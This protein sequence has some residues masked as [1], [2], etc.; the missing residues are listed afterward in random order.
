M[1]NRISCRGCLPFIAGILSWSG[2]F[3]Q[4]SV[5]RDLLTQIE[6]IRAVDN[7]AHVTPA[8]VPE[9]AEA[10]RPDPLGREPFAYPMRLLV[11]NAEY[12]DAWRGLY[13]YKYLDMAPDHT[14]EVLKTKLSLMREKGD[15][16]PSWVLDKANIAAVLVNMPSLGP[17]QNS[18]RFHWVPRADGFLF[19]FGGDDE[20]I[21]GFR[22][23]AG[24]SSQPATLA[25]YLETIRSRLDEWQAGGA[26]AIKFA[27]AYVRPLDFAPVAETDALRLFERH[28]QGVSLSAPEY[29]SVQ[30]FLFH[31]LAREAGRRGLI[32]QIHTGFGA[33]PYFNIGGSN[34]MLLEP[35][36]NDP[37]LRGTNFVLLHGGWP[38]DREAGALLMKPNVYADFSSQVFLRSTDALSSTL[39]TW[40]EW[41]PGKVL[42]GSDAYSE[43]TPLANWEEKI[44]LASRTSREALALALTQMMN[45]GEI[46]RARAVELAQM[47]LH[48]NATRLYGLQHP[49]ATAE[50]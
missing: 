13:E 9:T 47:V 18:S 12:V 2:V 50:R 43:D 1:L 8:R 10:E 40:L 45:A 41:Y 20:H 14:R 46:T 21:G 11:T 4:T 33:E 37:A 28:A 48:D 25:A 6:K 27:V 16:F 39:R 30:D 29:K 34:P 49:V 36:L 24:L 32:V 31:F 19:P 26:V 44:W 5:D 3:A 15:R 22:K 42:F 7:H 17:G 23:E 38:F 35:M